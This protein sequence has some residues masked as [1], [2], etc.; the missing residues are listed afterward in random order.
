[1]CDLSEKKLQI[2]DT[3]DSRG[4]YKILVEPFISIEMAFGE[5]DV[6][7]AIHHFFVPL[8]HR[9]VTPIEGYNIGDINPLR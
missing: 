3:V 9:A 4:D 5:I 7:D 2:I 1:M 8:V 6:P